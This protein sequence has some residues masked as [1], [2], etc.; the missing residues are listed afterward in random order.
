M[1]MKIVMYKLDILPNGTIA[2]KQCRYDIPIQIVTPPFYRIQYEYFFGWICIEAR[3]KW[4]NF[5]TSE[6][7]NKAD[8]WKNAY[9]FRFIA[10]KYGLYRALF[11]VP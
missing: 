3:D 4:P 7:S 9:D 10:Q 5:G 8:T 1:Q 6:R 2:D 11:I